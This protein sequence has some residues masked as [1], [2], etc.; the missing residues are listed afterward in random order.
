[1][2][3]IT[4]TLK[5]GHGKS[6]MLGEQL[7]GEKLATIH[8]QAAAHLGR[9][10]KAPG[11]AEFVPELIHNRSGV[12]S[13]LAVVDLNND[14]APE[15]ITGT[16]YGTFIFWNNCKRGLIDRLEDRTIGRLDEHDS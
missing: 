6:A 4:L 15:I 2:E 3:A 12:G 5:I 9:W 11:G 7:Y 1:L 16:K 8:W 10:P 13:H 14:K